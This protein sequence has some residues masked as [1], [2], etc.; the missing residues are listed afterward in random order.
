LAFIFESKIT[1]FVNDDVLLS[2]M[3]SGEYT[4]KPSSGV[5]FISNILGNFISWFHQNNISRISLYGIILSILNLIILFAVIKIIQ[6]KDNQTANW[7]GLSTLALIF[8]VLLISPTFTITAILLI[9]IGILG[10]TLCIVRFHEKNIHFVFFILLIIAGILIRIDALYGNVIFLLPACVAFIFLNYSNES[11][12]R[13]IELSSIT[14]LCIIAVLFYQ[15]TIQEQMMKIDYEFMNYVRF[16]DVLNT[17]T[18]ASLKLHQEIISGNVM[19]GIWSNVDFIILRNWAYADF[20]I[21][22]YKN[23]SL[24]SDS[25]SSFSGFKGVMNADLL[26]TLKLMTFYLKDQLQIII[27]LI[28]VSLLVLIKSINRKRTL[29]IVALLNLSYLAGFYFLAAILRIPDRTSFPLLIVFLIFLIISTEEKANKGEKKQYKLVIC[30]LLL[31]FAVLFHLNNNFGL[32][33]LISSNSNRLDFSFQRNAE[34]ENFSKNAIYVGPLTY[35][36]TVNQGIYSK[37]VYW[38][39]GERILPLSWATYSP[40]WYDMVR[41]LRLDDSNIYNSLAMQE[42]VYWVSNSYLAEILNMYMN[43]RQIY[44]GKLCSVAKLSGPDEAEIF[45]YQAK[46]DDC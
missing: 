14:I 35:F 43:D 39:S 33:K 17:Y 38:S 36:P 16:Q 7:L 13:F 31:I 41:K 1:F 10:I 19:R 34:L 6:M 27:G 25:V 32:S 28:S 22:G 3:L 12:R 37:N 11:N 5:T 9:G 23:M 45:T 4:G 26:E 15:H 46:E 8:P 24:G 20:S 2:Q 21:F 18:P 30:L 29:A 40:N 44:R 42:N